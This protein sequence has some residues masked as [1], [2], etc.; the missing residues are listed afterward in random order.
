MQLSRCYCQKWQ[1]C[2][3]K[4]RG[5]NIDFDL[6]S[7][8]FEKLSAEDGVVEGDF[9]RIVNWEDVYKFEL[10]Q[11]DLEVVGDDVD[12]SEVVAVAASHS[13]GEDGKP[14]G[15]LYLHNQYKIINSSLHL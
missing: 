1:G 7:V 4:E 13:F 3:N 8:L 6:I 5:T 9:G 2:L 11:L 15:T 10:F 14:V 12:G